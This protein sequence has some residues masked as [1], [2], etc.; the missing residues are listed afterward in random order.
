MVV[1]A[2]AT[3]VTT[4]DDSGNTWQGPPWADWPFRGHH[5]KGAPTAHPTKTSVV[6]HGVDLGHI[7]QFH[8]TSILAPKSR[9]MDR[10]VMV[11]TEA[12]L[13][14]NK[15]NKEASPFLS[16]LLRPCICSLKEFSGRL[17]GLVVRLPG[18]RFRGSGFDSHRYQIF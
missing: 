2:M 16:K 18:Y 6:E 1:I 3:M 13:L 7:T 5:V 11:A 9:Y 17:C 10:A 4:T 8:N 12:R 15:M 14:P